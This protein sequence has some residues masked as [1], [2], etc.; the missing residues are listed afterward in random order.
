MGPRELAEGFPRTGLQ[1]ANSRPTSMSLFALNISCFLVNRVRAR[2]C[3]RTLVSASPAGSSEFKPCRAQARRWPPGEAPCARTC[4]HL[5]GAG[6]WEDAGHR[7]RSWGRQRLAEMGPWL[8]PSRTIQAQVLS[9]QGRVRAHGSGRGRAA[10]P[11]LCR[12]GRLC[13]S[14]C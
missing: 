7:D 9:L 12:S 6:G 4:D 13:I 5:G 11:R 8:C 14:Q 3:V 1:P 2:V 10:G